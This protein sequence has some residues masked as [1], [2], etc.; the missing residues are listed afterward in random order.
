VNACLPTCCKSN[1][2]T[3]SRP[4]QR[5]GDMGRPKQTPALSIWTNGMLVGTWRMHGPSG[6]SMQY[7]TALV[8]SPF[9]RPLSL[10]FDLD[11]T[12]LKDS[13]VEIFINTLPTD[14][15]TIRSQLA[16]LFKTVSTDAFNLLQAICQFSASRS[17]LKALKLTFFGFGLCLYWASL[18]A[19]FFWWSAWSA[20]GA[21]CD[22]TAHQALC[23]SRSSVAERACP[24][25]ACNGHSVSAATPNSKHGWLC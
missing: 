15:D 25:K 4:I 23:P 17:Q 22:K 24:V 5:S 6:M 7:D 2:T 3:S 12:P 21:A 14:N 10:P 13:S 9:E 20:S 19:A 8:N 18:R 11:N 1:E 16:T